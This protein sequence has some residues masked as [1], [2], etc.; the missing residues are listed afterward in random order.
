MNHASYGERS[1]AHCLCD[2]SPLQCHSHSARQYQQR[3]PFGA[4]NPEPASLPARHCSESSNHRHGPV[5]RDGQGDGP[6]HRQSCHARLV[7]AS[8][9]IRLFQPPEAPHP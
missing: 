1:S 9:L 4:L 8:S 5:G 3:Q 6:T 7:C 2:R